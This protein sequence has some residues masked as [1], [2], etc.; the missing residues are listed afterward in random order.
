MARGSRAL[1]EKRLETEKAGDEAT[2]Q[3]GLSV[4]SRE[5]AAPGQVDFFF[6]FWGGA[7]GLF[8]GGRARRAGSEIRMMEQNSIEMKRCLGGLGRRTHDGVRDA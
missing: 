1:V 2:P 3:E 7:G 4:R 8:A 6:V 5:N